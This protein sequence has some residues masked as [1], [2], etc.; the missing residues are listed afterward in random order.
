MLII[1]IILIIILLMNFVINLFLTTNDNNY[2]LNIINKIFKFV[3]L[4]VENEK[5]LTKV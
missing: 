4:F 1:E 2:L 5:N 3:R